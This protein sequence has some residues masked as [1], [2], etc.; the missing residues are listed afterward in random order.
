M[1][2]AGGVAL[3]ALVL[4]ATSCNR[5][6]RNDTPVDAASASSV[7]GAPSASPLPSDLAEAARQAARSSD[8][9]VEYALDTASRKGR[10]VY[11]ARAEKTL[12]RLEQ[13]PSQSR[14]GSPEG[15]QSVTAWVLETPTDTIFCLLE[16]EWR[17]FEGGS[18]KD[19]APVLF[20]RRS[21]EFLSLVAP[22][23]PSDNYKKTEENFA[24][25]S[26]SCFDIVPQPQLFV[27]S[28]DEGEAGAGPV[29]PLTP[30]PKIDPNSLELL[31]SSLI[32]EVLYRGGTMCFGSGG[33]L[34]K[35]TV[36]DAELFSIT[37]DRVSSPSDSDFV[38]PTQPERLG[39]PSPFPS[40]IHAT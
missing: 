1:F 11:A 29:P 15:A 17:C 31:R 34:L 2:R 26:A 32:V 21:F 7:E 40:V 28:S 10:L 23:I 18:S 36:L 8:R 16:K 25:Y 35:L 4:T 27:G 39:T 22:S 38:P 33:V 14:K 6:V 3:V 37:A 12:W 19:E 13:Q 20:D 5:P 30:I 9:K 24:G